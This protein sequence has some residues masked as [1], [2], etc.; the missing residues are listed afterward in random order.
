MNKPNFKQIAADILDRSD[1]EAALEAV[2]D[3]G[4][5]D[6]DAHGWEVCVDWSDYDKEASDGE[7]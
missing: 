3:I 7:T 1:L 4:F 2:Y 6:G 5:E